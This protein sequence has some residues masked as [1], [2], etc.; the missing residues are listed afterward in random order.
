MGSRGGR[1][2]LLLC[3]VMGALFGVAFSAQS[4]STLLASNKGFSACQDLPKLASTLAWRIDNATNSVDFA[5]SASAPNANGWVAWGINPTAA[6]GQW[7]AGTQALVAYQTAAGA[8]VAGYP[9]TGA[10]KGGAPAVPGTLSVNFTG[11]STVITGTEMTIYTTLALKANDSFTMNNVWNVGPSVDQTSFAIASHSLSGDSLS[12]GS[13]IDLSSGQAFNNIELPNQKLKN[14]HAI[15]SA[16]AWGLLLPLGVMA[17]RY[18]RPFSNGNPAWFYIHVTCQ[19]TGYAL[20]V[21]AWA[22]GMRLHSLNQGL[23]PYKHRN[24]GI[25]IFALAT[26]QVLAIFLRPNPDAKYRKYWNVYH[27]SVGYATLVLIIINIFEGLDLLQPGNKWTLI[28]VIILCAL[29]AISLI[30][31][32]ITWSKWIRERNSNKQAMHGSQYK[33]SSAY[34]SG[35]EDV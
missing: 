24:L 6:N 14:N 20:G 22:L 31:E 16:V 11:T 13:V 18:L 17:A 34:R 10:M 25:S 28:Y 33:G 3:V 9:I 21:I 26:L 4:C 27:H 30:M 19:C 2:V 1:D 7:M 23:V 32:I 12:S 29:G 35:R 15:I 8:K 5:F